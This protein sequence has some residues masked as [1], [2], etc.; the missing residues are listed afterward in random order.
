MPYYNS[1]TTV[2]IHFGTC[3]LSWRYIWRIDE[4]ENKLRIFNCVQRNWQDA[5]ESVAHGHNVVLNL[6]K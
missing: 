1:S 5:N 2:A 3:S 6:L 4:L